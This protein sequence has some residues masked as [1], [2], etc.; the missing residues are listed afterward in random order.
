MGS[1]G[2]NEWADMMPQ[3]VTIEPWLSY[4]AGGSGSTYGGSTSYLCRIEM[5]NHLVVDQSGNIVTARGKVFLLSTDTIGSKDRVTLPIGFVP[6]QPPI[7]SVD[8]ADDESGNH[9]VALH[10]GL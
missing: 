9:H 2:V 3:T 7:I 8:V 5:I 4:T 10:F 6:T 1:P